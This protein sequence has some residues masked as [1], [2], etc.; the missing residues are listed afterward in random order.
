[1]TAFP[2]LFLII[3]SSHHHNWFCTGIVPLCFQ[4]TGSVW[5]LFRRKVIAFMFSFGIVESCVLCSAKGCWHYGS[6]VVALPSPRYPDTCFYFRLP[7]LWLHLY[8]FFFL[9]IFQRCFIQSLKILFP[10]VLFSANAQ[11]A[12]RRRALERLR[13]L[14]K[15]MKSVPHRYRHRNLCENQCKDWLLL[16][17][18]TVQIPPTGWR[19]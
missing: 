3:C 19:I 11:V 13:R 9:L 4:I 6:L 15:G 1:M 7:L 12:Q 14:M 18:P 10:V 17:V 16:L 5:C 8:D 2:S